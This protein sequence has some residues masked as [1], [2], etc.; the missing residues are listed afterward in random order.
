[1]KCNNILILTQE[2]YIQMSLQDVYAMKYSHIQL[3]LLARNL[4]PAL[5]VS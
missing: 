1:M 5:E 4:P 3:V 2:A